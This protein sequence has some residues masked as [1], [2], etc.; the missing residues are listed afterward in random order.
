VYISGPRGRLSAEHYDFNVGDQKPAGNVTRVVFENN[1][2]RPEGGRRRHRRG[3][4]TGRKTIQAMNQT[5][6]GPRN[7]ARRSRS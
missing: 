2:G 7:E 3:Q 6:A 4:V 5:E 1:R